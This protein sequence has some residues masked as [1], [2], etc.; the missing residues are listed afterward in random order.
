MRKEIV[1]IGITLL[2]LIILIKLLSSDKNSQIVKSSTPTP[3]PLVILEV[4]S[5][6]IFVKLPETD[7]EIEAKTLAEIPIGTHIKA[8]DNGR[9]QLLYPNG[10]V[11]RLD[12][13]A[14]ITLGE[15]N[16][17]PFRVNIILE[18][19]RVW[20]RIVKL[21]GGEFYQTETSTLIA[22]IRGTSYNHGFLADGSARGIVTKGKVFMQCKTLGSE[23][24]VEKGNLAITDCDKR[25]E[26]RE[27]SKQ[28]F[29]D[30]WIVFN[31]QQDE[32]LDSRFG[33]DR[34]SD[35]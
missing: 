34:Y 29:E 2:L 23:L 7:V 10:S 21:L 17:S 18:K 12:F 32:K 31:I 22:S 4:F 19:G 16:N 1:F 11:T 35:E 5:D 33:K 15:F 13:N 30:P 6:T 24:V 14:E 26:S 25:T 9:G 28:E 3:T 27:I 20:S 8:S